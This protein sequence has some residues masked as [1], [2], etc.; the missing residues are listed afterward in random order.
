MEHGRLM[1]QLEHEAIVRKMA[2]VFEGVYHDSQCPITLRDCYI[3]LGYSSIEYTAKVVTRVA[4]EHFKETGQWGYIIHCDEMM[5]SKPL[6]DRVAMQAQ[7]VRGK[8]FR[9]VYLKIKKDWVSIVSENL[10]AKTGLLLRL[11]LYKSNRFKHFF[12]GSA[13][14]RT[15]AAIAT[16]GNL[17]RTSTRIAAGNRSS[18]ELS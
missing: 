4:E 6:F 7:S 13:A 18:G 3:C 2:G 17:Q 16:R 5:L 8:T 9:S 15:Q 14:W 11:L 10:L 12:S 1:T